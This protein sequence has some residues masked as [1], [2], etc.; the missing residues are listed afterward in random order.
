MVAAAA[1]AAGRLH[2]IAE[3]LGVEIGHFFADVDPAGLL[4][5]AEPGE[6]GRDLR[7]DQQ[8]MLLELARHVAAIGDRGHRE[9]VCALARALAAL[10]GEKPARAADQSVAT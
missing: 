4:G 6:A 2:R 7:Q 3:V 5:G 9:A 1:T 8:R 10:G